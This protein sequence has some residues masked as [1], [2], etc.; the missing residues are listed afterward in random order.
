MEFT[1]ETEVIK[2]N[3]DSCSFICNFSAG[4]LEFKIGNKK[5]FQMDYLNFKEFS[6]IINNCS[7]EYYS[8]KNKYDELY[9]SNYYRKK[10][11][12]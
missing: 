12:E 6:E 8:H 9:K 3:D 1:V 7:E 11:Y 5:S 2:N 10:I 4:I